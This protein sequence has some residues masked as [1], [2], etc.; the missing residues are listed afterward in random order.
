M[1]PKKK[2]KK[3]KKKGKAVIQGPQPVTTAQIL[4]NRTK[5][6]CPRLGDA[7]TMAFNVEEILQ[8]IYTFPAQ[9]FNCK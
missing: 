6:F 2:G 1:P 3:G 5:M 7:Y 8:V 9:L 4:D